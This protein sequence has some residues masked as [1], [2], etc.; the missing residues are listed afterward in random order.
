[1]PNSEKLK[2]KIKDSGMTMT[3]ICEKSGIDRATLYNRL[4]GR[5]EW[6]AAEIV[7]MSN[8]LRLTNEEKVD[9]FLV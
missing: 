4:K 1:M 7:S 9:I 8:A 2:E 5:G 3:A 6:K